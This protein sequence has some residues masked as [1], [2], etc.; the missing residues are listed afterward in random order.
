MLLGWLMKG[1]TGQGAGGARTVV[2]PRTPRKP[3]ANFP[4]LPTPALTLLISPHV[5]GEVRLSMMHGKCGP[6]LLLPCH[7]SIRF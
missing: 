2:S 4:A 6:R 5:F 7:G 1:E 3:A